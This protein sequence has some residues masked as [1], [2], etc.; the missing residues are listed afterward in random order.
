M[1]GLIFAPGNRVVI[2]DAEWLVKNVSHTAGNTC[3]LD[4]VGLSEIVQDTQRKFAVHLEKGIT[5][6]DPKDTEFTP[7]HSPGYHDTLLFM[8]SMLRRR[9]PK[10]EKIYI[11]NK[12]A[13]DLVPYQVEPAVKALKQYRQRILIADAVGLGKTIECGILLS[14]LI[15]RGRGKRILVLAVKSMLTQ[16]QK[17]MWTRFTIPL[18]RLD[19]QGIQRV[20]QHIPAGHNPF[21]YF[22]NSIISID[23]LK[24]EAEYRHY[25]EHAWWDIIV[26]DEAHNVAERGSNSM[27]SKLAKLISSR[28]DTLI[29]LSATPHDGKKE[30]FASLMNML[31]PTAIA[32]PSNYGPEDIRGLFIR[33]FKKDIKHQVTRQFRDRVIT[34]HAAPAGNLEEHAYQ[35]L[36]DLQFR[37]IDS[38]ARAGTMLFKTVLEKSLFSSPSACIKTCENRINRLEQENIAEY[39]DDIRQLEQFAA[40][41][42]EITAEHFSK[43]QFLVSFLKENKWNWNRKDPSD[44]LVIFTERIETMRFLF[45]HL[46]EDLGLKDKEIGMLYGS[47]SDLDIQQVVEQFGNAQEPIRVL[48]ASDVAS[49]GINLHYQ[50]HRMIHFDIPWSLMVFQQRNGRI[51]RYGQQKDPLIHYLLTESD[52]IKIRGDMR[53]LQL[54]IEKDQQVHESIG[55]PSEFSGKYTIEDEE[56]LTAAAVESATGE[57]VLTHAFNE[58]QHDPMAELLGI[59]SEKQEEVL[60]PMGNQHSFFSK[61]YDYVK[62]AVRHLQTRQSWNV[63]FDEDGHTILLD[64]LSALSVLE[65]S[66]PREVVPQSHEQYILTDHVEQ[67]MDEMERCRQEETAWPRVML[68]WNQNPLVSWITDRMITLF[69]RNQAPLI[70]IPQYSGKNET[71]LL[72]SGMISNRKGQAVV[73]DWF[74]VVFRDSVFYQ[75]ISLETFMKRTGMG[76]REIPNPRTPVAQDEIRFLV[77]EALRQGRSHL[78]NLRDQF[79]KCINPQLVEQYEQLKVLKHRQLKVVQESERSRSRREARERSIERVFDDYQQWID[80]TLRCADDPYLRILCAVREGRL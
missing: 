14:E 79:I 2:R 36:V 35:L 56:L 6:L 65:K 47:M 78:S 58:A 26:I 67:V 33:R 9:T 40:A 49:E 69:G 74:A 64:R 51:D 53:I 11:G 57:Q 66:L 22:D 23:T 72:I 44:R 19:S 45:H 46:K 18:V 54:L 25:L 76:L 5:I 71:I 20:K 70:T 7:D 48:I 63:E 13:I 3:I 28:S 60:D 62:A 41:V 15:K 59:L 30:S 21:L 80:S 55:D 31:D 39:I 75:V 12:A 77:P 42:K 1:N 32:D 68:L 27:R 8:E 29:M 38:R 16:F 37:K 17:E 61:D 24:R 73:E 10:D 50:C 4:V 43:Y 34:Q 52:H